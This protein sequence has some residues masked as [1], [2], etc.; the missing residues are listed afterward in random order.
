[1]LALNT[2][3]RPRSQDCTTSITGHRHP[4]ACGSPAAVGLWAA[5]K[6]NRQNRGKEYDT[7]AWCTPNRCRRRV[8]AEVGRGS[9]AIMAS[10]DA[11][12]K[13]NVGEEHCLSRSSA[14]RSQLANAAASWYDRVDGHVHGTHA[15]AVKPLGYEN[16]NAVSPRCC[17]ACCWR[18]AARQP[19]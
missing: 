6:S 10:V 17:W 8:H 9:A 13:R 18:V 12:K 7:A 11:T 2:Q 19:R 15:A 14:A 16:A 4:A 5:E 1:M 3:T